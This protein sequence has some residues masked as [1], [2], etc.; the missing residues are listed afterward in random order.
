M[1]TFNANI[2]EKTTE[3]KIQNAFDKYRKMGCELSDEKLLA[4]CTKKFSVNKK[5]EKRS[6]KKWA[7]RDARK[8]VVTTE[9]DDMGAYN[10][11]NAMIN[12]PSSM[13]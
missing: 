6:I 10:R 1:K 12:L 9:I 3:E 8:N 5:A 7:D 4:M 11:A 2:T 13:R